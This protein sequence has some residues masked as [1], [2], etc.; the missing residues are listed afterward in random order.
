MHRGVPHRART[1]RGRRRRRRRRG[2]G[3][4][5]INHGPIKR[6]VRRLPGPRQQGRGDRL[7]VRHPR[8][9]VDEGEENVNEEE[10]AGTTTR[11]QC[12]PATR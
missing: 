4:A 8:L 11:Q 10:R 6:A 5:A 3:V 12:R 1:R 7:A 2:A 9:R